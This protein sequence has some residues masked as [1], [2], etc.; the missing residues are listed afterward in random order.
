MKNFIQVRDKTDT[1]T[2]LI[3]TEFPHF[4]C[5]IEQ[6]TKPIKNRDDF[7]LYGEIFFTETCELKIKEMI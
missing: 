6:P 1:K 3:H 5:E 2:I 7:K 4:I